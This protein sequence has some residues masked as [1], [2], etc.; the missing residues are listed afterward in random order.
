MQSVGF[1]GAHL[2]SALKCCFV[3]IREAMHAKKH[4]PH[5]YTTSSSLNSCWIH[6]VKWQLLTETAANYR[7]NWDSSD[8]SFSAYCNFRFLFLAGSGNRCGRQLL[9]TQGSMSCVFCVLC[10][11]TWLSRLI[12]IWFICYHNLLVNFDPVWLF[13]SDRS[14][15]QI[16]YAQR[17]VWGF[18]IVGF[19][20]TLC[21]L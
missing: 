19:C 5:H 15:E 18:F 3:V 2:Y 12:A 8:T 10:C 11:S 6:V 21:K 1:K 16:G 9:W 17:A 7:R 13:S 14:R 20:T 4:F